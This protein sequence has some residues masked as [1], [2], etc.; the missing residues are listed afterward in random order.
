[1][2]S[3]RLLNAIGKIDDKM[4]EEAWETPIKNA[5]S[6]K[7]NKKYIWYG[8]KKLTFSFIYDILFR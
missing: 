3:E 5:D 2:K 4:I 7:R 6:R 1:M 8:K